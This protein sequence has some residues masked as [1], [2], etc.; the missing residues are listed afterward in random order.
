MRLQATI[1][2]LLDERSSSAGLDSWLGSAEET[3]NSLKDVNE[4]GVIAVYSRSVGE[5]TLHRWIPYFAGARVYHIR[6]DDLVHLVYLEK[7]G[8]SMA[9]R[10]ELV[11]RHV[12]NQSVE[13]CRQLEADGVTHVWMTPNANFSAGQ[14]RSAQEHSVE[15]LTC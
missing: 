1:S 15:S 9:K 4:D 2:M 11:R 7:D 13:A 6:D 10:Q 12:E 3:A 14:A 5:Q 8:D